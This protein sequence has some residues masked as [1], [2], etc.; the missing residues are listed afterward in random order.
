VVAGQV[1]LLLQ[2]Q[3]IAVQTVAQAVEQLEEVLEVAQLQDKVMRADLLA[4]LMVGLAAAGQVR[5]VLLRHRRQV[6]LAV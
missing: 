4:Q 2:D 3:I 5:R 1:A 6:R